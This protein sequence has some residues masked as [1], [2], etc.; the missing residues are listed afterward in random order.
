[1][2]LKRVVVQNFRVIER[3]EVEFGPGLNVLFG[4][5]DIGK[6]TIAAAVRAA[7]LLQASSSE[8]ET[9]KPWRGD[10]VPDV[11]LTFEV[12]D[13]GVFRVSKK[14]GGGIKSAAK[15]E[16]SKDGVLFDQDATARQVEDKLRTMLQWGIAGMGGKGAK[17]GLPETFLAQALLGEQTDVDA[18]L[19]ESLG[20]DDNDSGRLRITSAL[21]VLAQDP[22]F[23][24]IL[25]AAQTKV[26]E[27]FTATGKPKR[28]KG[29]P[30]L[31][32]TEKVTKLQG[33]V[34]ALRTKRDSSSLAL[35][36]FQKLQAE[37]DGLVQQLEAARAD[38]TATTKRAAAQAEFEK[39]AAQLA[40]LDAKRKRAEE[41]GVELAG[42]TTLLA[43]LSEKVAQAETRVA[44]ATAKLE[45][46]REALRLATSDTATQERE[47]K[48]A[49]L[50][51]ANSNDALKNAELE[52]QKQA[53]EVALL[54]AGTVNG[55]DARRVELEKRRSTAQTRAQAAQKSA[56]EARQFQHGLTGLVAL[57]RWHEAA[58]KLKEAEHSLS[59]T[60]RLAT[61]VAGATDKAERLRAEVA[62]L[63]LPPV[64]LVKE[65]LQLE[66]ELAVANAALG[67]GMSLSLRTQKPSELRVVVDGRTVE[68]GT[69]THLEAQRTLELH[70][71][72][73]LH[74]ELLAGDATKRAAFAKLQQSHEKHAPLLIK[75][76]VATASELLKKVELAE[77]NLA[78][79][80]KHAREAEQFEVERKRHEGQA[81]A[82]E[83]QRTKVA[84][85][86][87]A[88]EGHD[89]QALDTLHSGLTPGWEKSTAEKQKA[90]ASTERAARDAE[91]TA[92]TD[93]AVCSGE[94]TQLEGQLVAERAK[95]DGGLKLLG[96]DPVTLLQDLARRGV[97]YEHRRKTREAELRA[98]EKDSGQAAENARN[99]VTSAQAAVETATSSRTA[100]QKA[101][102]ELRSKV[103]QTKGTHEVL[104]R[105][106]ASGDRPAVLDRVAQKEQALAQLPA[107]RV[108]RT[109]EDIHS[110]D[111]I[112]QAK[113]AEVNQAEGALT[114]V[115][116][117]VIEEQLR[118]FEAAHKEAVSDH[119]KLEIDSEAW[120]LLREALAESESI[121]S[122]HVGRVLSE[123]VGTHFQEL[124]QRGYGELSIDPHLHTTGVRIEGV[125]RGVDSLSVG[126]REQL[127]TLLR[128]A[129]AESLKSVIVLDDHL[130]QTDPDRL[131]WFVDTLQE[132]AK[133]IQVIVITCRRRDYEG[134]GMVTWVDLDAI[135]KRWPKPI[136]TSVS[137]TTRELSPAQAVRAAPIAA[138]G[139]PSAVPPDPPAGPPAKEDDPLGTLLENA[140]A[141]M[142]LSHE[143][144]AQQVGVGLRVV[145]LW[146]KGSSVPAAQFRAAVV[147][148]LKKE[149][150]RDDSARARAAARLS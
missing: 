26:D 52:S 62:A 81:S 38:F 50:A 121:G 139:A 141:E 47:T 87:A 6:S 64:A 112:L 27:L 129:I 78:S 104:Q 68:V 31:G 2:R 94:L 142:G 74:L 122:R 97:E 51:E 34:E 116:G 140:L 30:F 109:A 82:L 123:Q 77:L 131:A 110:L 108:S 23:K 146:L 66:H 107:P 80:E 132:A 101:H 17:H 134:T 46:A 150:C 88:L 7:L 135:I 69:T 128:L 37:V 76:G 21:Q 102:Q 24:R 113:R 71:S 48:K 130:V 95:L 49:R 117:A 44:E 1:M 84:D 57:A 63:A 61:A 35:G 32:A 120:R 105:E 40:E 127:A 18:I 136:S 91:A 14:F 92:R 125:E 45:A 8:A 60:T 42:F 143:A 98:L 39:A 3:A 5:N 10:L 100:A 67:G 149:R 86:A 124:T 83:T 114:Q 148:L 4:P 53:A 75:A 118:E 99:A 55:L 15:L 22:R 79:A 19:N 13:K 126:T 20:N 72:E 147:T 28:S 65:M 93:L 25:D 96:A 111:A 119:K 59:E 41:S 54:L 106:A 73:V 90:Y 137:T 12:R 138:A 133:Q 36:Q 70:L 58:L 33:E 85:C 9:L 89:R 115:G 103:D 145:E 56:E 29:S 144:F 16:R 11:E 43:G